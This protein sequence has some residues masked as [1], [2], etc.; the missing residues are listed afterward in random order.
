MPNGWLPTGIVALTLICAATVRATFHAGRLDASAAVAVAA[1][2]SA[3]ITIAAMMTCRI[4]AMVSCFL[5]GYAG[6]CSR[7]ATRRLAVV[8]SV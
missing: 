8:P 4:R 6:P 7:S 2:E 5:G 1:D 3:A